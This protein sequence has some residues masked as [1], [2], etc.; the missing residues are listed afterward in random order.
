MY[1]VLWPPSWGTIFS[2]N[3]FVPIIVSDSK[4]KLVV[5]LHQ[6]L[7]CPKLIRL[8]NL[9]FCY[10]YNYFPTNLCLS[11][12][13]HPMQILISWVCILNVIRY[14]YARSHFLLNLISWI[15]SAI[16]SIVSLNIRIVFLYY[17]ILID[18][19]KS[20]ADLA[21]KIINWSAPFCCFKFLVIDIQRFP[22]FFCL[23]Y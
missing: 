2:F 14:V 6:M 3:L 23:A 9:L 10:Q 22:S 5:F 7:F 12:K 15:I 16:C 21:C 17:I 4:Y 11:S 13:G 20:Y 18:S 1:L 19:G 8:V